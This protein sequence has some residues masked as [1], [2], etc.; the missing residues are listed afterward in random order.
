MQTCIMCFQMTRGIEVKVVSFPH[1]LVIKKRYE[2]EVKKR[3]TSSGAYK[4]LVPFV[5]AEDGSRYKM[6]LSLFESLEKVGERGGAQSCIC[7]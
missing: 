3:L 1:I 7:H 6:G 5:M 4:T 2:P